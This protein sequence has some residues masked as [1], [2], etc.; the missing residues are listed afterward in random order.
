[1]KITL[2]ALAEKWGALSANAP[3]ARAESLEAAAES[4][5]IKYP[6]ASEPNPKLDRTKNSLR[7]LTWIRRL[8]EKEFMRTS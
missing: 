3:A 8:Q 2:L 5:F 4:Q 1:M 7:E 6:S